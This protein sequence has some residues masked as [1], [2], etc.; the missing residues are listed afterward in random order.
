[1]SPHSIGLLLLLLG[2]SVADIAIKVQGVFHRHSRFMMANEMLL[3]YCMFIIA[4]FF[5]RF[6]SFDVLPQLLPRWLSS[7]IPLPVMQPVR[8]PT[9]PYPMSKIVGQDMVKLALLLAAGEKTADG[10]IAFCLHW[11]FLVAL[12]SGVCCLYLCTAS[13][14]IPSILD[15]STRFVICGRI[16]CGRTRRSPQEFCFRW[17]ALTC[18]LHN[19]VNIS[20]H[21][22][23]WHR[24]CVCFLLI[25]VVS[26]V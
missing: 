5:F 4:L 25:R 2:T 23:S 17:E 20:A 18:K 9:R 6:V 3:P 1:M 15:E 14:A 22:K 12:G 8:M 19:L 7:M 24:V 10:M 26:A 16:R 11:S 13:S 21:S